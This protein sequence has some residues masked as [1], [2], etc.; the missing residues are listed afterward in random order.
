MKSLLATEVIILCI[1]S[2]VT[3]ECLPSTLT[4]NTVFL[5]SA[6]LPSASFCRTSSLNKKRKE[7]KLEIISRIYLIGLQIHQQVCVCECE[8]LGNHIWQIH[9][10]N[11]DLEE[12]KLKICS[13]THTHIVYSIKLLKLVLSVNYTS[14][15]LCNGGNMSTLVQILLGP[16]IH[17]KVLL[18]MYQ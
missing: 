4:N 10:Y 1:L 12:Y 11:L 16:T 8:V 9:V 6:M 13:I 3:V 7:R 5:S 14:S 15:L 2:M 18:C 17:Q